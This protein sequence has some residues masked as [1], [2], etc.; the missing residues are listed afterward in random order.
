ML[1]ESPEENSEAKRAA[2]L[3]EEITTDKTETPWISNPR[4]FLK[5]ISNS[6]E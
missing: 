2:E 3:P 1:P 5:V 6:E 4:C